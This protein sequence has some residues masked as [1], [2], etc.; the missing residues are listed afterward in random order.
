MP[1]AEIR[2]SKSLTLKFGLLPAQLE[3]EN[4]PDAEIRRNLNSVCPQPDAENVPGPNF[5]FRAEPNIVFRTEFRL[6]GRISSSGPNVVFRAEFRL[7][8]PISSSGPNFVFA[9]EFRLQGRLSRLQRSIPEPRTL[10][11]S[12]CGPNFV[13]RTNF[14]FTNEFRP[15]VCPK[16]NFRPSQEF[17]LHGRFSSSHFV[18]AH[19]LSFSSLRTISSSK[20]SEFWLQ[21]GRNRDPLSRVN[22][23]P[24][25]SFHYC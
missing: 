18:F 23:C 10:S 19:N 24:D 25:H 6:R 21:G 11:N 1:E 22:A 13:F 4:V 20:A 3:A 12:V 8:G 7:Q 5:V 16:P 14:V 2:H 17:R 15:S 9:A